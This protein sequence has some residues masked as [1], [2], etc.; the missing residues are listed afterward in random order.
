MKICLHRKVAECHHFFRCIYVSRFVDTAV[1][2]MVFVIPNA[3]DLARKLERLLKVGLRS[4]VV[5]LLEN[6]YVESGCQ[7]FLCC[8]QPDTP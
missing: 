3:T 7:S 4:Y 1:C 8:H 6:C 2:L 5:A